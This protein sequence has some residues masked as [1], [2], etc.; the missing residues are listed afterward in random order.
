MNFEEALTF[1]LEQVPKLSGKVYPGFLPGKTAPYLVYLSSPGLRTKVLE[2]GYL[3]S[4]EV[5]ATLNVITSKYSDLKIIS[6]AVIDKVISFQGRA[7]GNGG[8]HIQ[9]VTYEEPKELYEPEPNLY[10][11]V[12]EIQVYFRE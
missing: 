8:P 6:D 11:C 1:E 12:I 5:S 10:R 9:E 3:T 7:I 4:K 2:S